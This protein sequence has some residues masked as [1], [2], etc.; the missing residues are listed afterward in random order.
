MKNVLFLI[1]IG[2]LFIFLL[3]CQEKSHDKII[4]PVK[5]MKVGKS[6][7]EGK[8]FPGYAEAEEYAYLTFRVG[9]MLLHFDLQE[10]QDL[11]AG[12]LVGSIDPHDYNLKLASTKANFLQARSQAERYQRL[13]G[14]NAVSKQ[15]YEIAQATYENTKSVYKQALDDVSYT[16]LI[17]PFSGNVEKKYVENHQ[18]VA[19]GEKIIKLNNPLKIQFRFIIPETNARYLHKNAECSVELDVEK[20]VFYKAKVKEVISSSVGGSGVPVIVAIDDKNYDPAKVKVMPGYACNVRIDS[21]TDANGHALITI[22]L[23]CIYT[24]PESGKRYVWKVDES[25]LVVHKVL[26]ETGELSG[27]K[28]IIILSGLQEGDRIVTAGVTMLSEGEHVKIIES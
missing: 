21:K 14:K 7:W 15:E 23:I 3:S 27:E 20:G 16:R 9:G 28:D 1:L 25:Q 11:K 17:A 6:T 26:V 12:E 4:R 2:G 13:Y 10:G 8:I 24:D 5:T 19:A 22:P 18:Q